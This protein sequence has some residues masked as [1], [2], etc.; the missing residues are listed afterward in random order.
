[1]WLT[2]LVEASS[3]GENHNSRKRIIDVSVG[4]ED[5]VGSYKRLLEQIHYMHV[6]V[7]KQM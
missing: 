5:K 7:V 2:G 4:A 3:R 1:M 6:H